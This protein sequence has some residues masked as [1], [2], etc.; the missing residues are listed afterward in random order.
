MIPKGARKYRFFDRSSHIW[1]LKSFRDTHVY[2]AQAILLPKFSFSQDF[3]YC[4]LYVELQT[5]VIRIGGVYVPWGPLVLLLGGAS[6]Y[7][8]CSYWKW[9]R[10]F[11]TKNNLCMTLDHFLCKVKNNKY[12][13]SALLMTFQ[14]NKKTLVGTSD[15][16]FLCSFEKLT[17][18]TLETFDASS[19]SQTAI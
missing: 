16:F 3:E 18:N 5:P 17:R 10:Q 15:A 4:A 13:H 1:L 6:K 12:T 19:N 2:C 7:C 9:D 8:D 14:G 11:Q